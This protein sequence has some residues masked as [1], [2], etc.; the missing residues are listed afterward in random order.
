LTLIDGRPIGTPTSFEEGMVDGSLADIRGIQVK[1][2]DQ[3]FVIEGQS[4][5]Y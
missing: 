2:H 4:P 3:R 5:N 1:V